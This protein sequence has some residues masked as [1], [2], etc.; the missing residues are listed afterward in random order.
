[1]SLLHCDTCPRIVDTD[2]DVE[3]TYDDETGVF[4]CSKCCEKWEALVMRG[5]EP[6]N[7]V[8]P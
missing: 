7:P 5:V 6:A 1:V 2:H 4:S 8:T 3:G